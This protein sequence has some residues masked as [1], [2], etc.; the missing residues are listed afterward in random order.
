MVPAP[1]YLQSTQTSTASSHDGILKLKAALKES[2]N[3]QVPVVTSSSR[4]SAPLRLI[5]A[6]EKRGIHHFNHTPAIGTEF[7]KGQLDLA[8][9]LQRPEGDQEADELLRELAVMSECFL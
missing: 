6:F 4:L 8:E 1:A 7:E 5:N 9:L 3:N 2:S